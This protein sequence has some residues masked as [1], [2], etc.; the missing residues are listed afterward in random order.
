MI[1]SWFETT[2]PTLL[3]NYKLQDI[4]NADEFGLFFQ[5]LPNKTYHFKAEKCS[6]GKNSKVRITGHVAANAVG[7]KLP[8]FVI[9]KSKKPRCFKNV[10]SLPCRYRAQKKSWM[11]RSL[12]EWVREIN[13]MFLEQGRKIVLIIDNCPAH[14]D[15]DGL[16]NVKL[17]FLPP[18]T[19]SVSQPMDQGVIR[20]LK[21]IYRR[22]LVNMMIQQLEKG[23]DLPK[24]SILCALQILVSSCNQV[25]KIKKE[26]QKNA[27]DDIEDPF[28]LLE[29]E[30]SQ[31]RAID[32]TVVPANL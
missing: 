31:L 25:K 27:T 9:G 24:I 22:K 26:D 19:T 18:N 20:C 6:G 1:A 3:T 10:T 14:P 28:K 15:V 23:K 8:I 17:I 30:R 2:L 11:D 12:F 32:D 16:S 7:E 29:E 4:Y 5:C 13:A 21:A